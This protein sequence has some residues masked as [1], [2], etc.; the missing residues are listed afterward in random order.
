MRPFLLSKI[1]SQQIVIFN[2]T[3][4][5]LKIRVLS[6]GK[7]NITLLAVTGGFGLFLISTILFV[8]N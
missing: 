8:I 5:Q 4:I 2:T 6:K 1:R 3:D 7:M